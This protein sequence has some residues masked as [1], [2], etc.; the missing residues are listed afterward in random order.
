M[1]QLDFWATHSLNETFR[2]NYSPNTQAF[3]FL[4]PKFNNDDFTNLSLQLANSEL[5][6]PEN[7]LACNNIAGL[8]APNRYE[9]VPGLT[10]SALLLS[11]VLAAL[12]A[13][14]R[15]RKRI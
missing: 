14:L 8:C 7:F 13:I 10:G 12:G 4:A 6:I 3:P 2:E 11:V 5:T 9:A 15:H 1:K